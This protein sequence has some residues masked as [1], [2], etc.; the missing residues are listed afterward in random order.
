MLQRGVSMRDSAIYGGFRKGSFSAQ[1]GEV[2]LI[3]RQNDHRNI[4]SILE[5]NINNLLQVSTNTAGP[6]L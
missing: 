5:V 3:L 4:T 2:N 1:T 6:H